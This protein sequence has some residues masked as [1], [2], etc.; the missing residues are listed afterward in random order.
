MEY[1]VLERTNLVICL[2]HA[3]LLG[4]MFLFLHFGLYTPSWKLAYTTFDHVSLCIYKVWADYLATVNVGK[5]LGYEC[6]LLVM[7]INDPPFTIL[8]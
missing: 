3:F 2:V 6:A 5:L 1:R 7:A 4:F 8:V